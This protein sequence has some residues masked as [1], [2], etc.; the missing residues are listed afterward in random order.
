MTYKKK[1][2]RIQEEIE[3]HVGTISQFPR[4]GTIPLKNM[5]A[6]LLRLKAICDGKSLE[7]AIEIQSKYMKE[8]S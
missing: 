1:F 8:E 4:G 7:E 2:K 3:V 5:S 6:L